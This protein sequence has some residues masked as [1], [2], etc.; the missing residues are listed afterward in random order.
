M[1]SYI[2][3]KQQVK[4]N[5]MGLLHAAGESFLDKM[6]AQQSLDTGFTHKTI[7][8]IIDDLE[9]LGYVEIKGNTIKR[10]PPKIADEVPE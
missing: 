4:K 1:T 8:A 7:R 6:I 9:S 5:I 3:L 10:T 2:V